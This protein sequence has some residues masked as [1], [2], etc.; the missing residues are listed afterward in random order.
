MRNILDFEAHFEGAKVV[1]LEENYRSRKTILDVANVVLSNASGKRHGKTCVATRDGG[2][3]VQVVVAADPEVEAS[4]VA[5]E[6]QRLIEGGLVGESGRSVRPRDVA[7]LYRSNLQSADIES[8]L[9]ERQIPYRMIGGTQFYERKEVKDLIA[10]LRVAIDPRDELSLR[11]IINYPARGI[12]DAAVTRLASQATAD[13]TGLWNVVGRPDAVSG[14]APAAVEGCRALVRVIEAVRQRFET[15]MKSAEV[16][17]ALVADLGMKEDIHAG[18]TNPQAAARRLGNLESMISV[19]GRRDERGLGDRGKFAEFLRVLALREEGEEEDSGDRVTLT[20]MHGAKGLEF[21]VVFVIGLEEGLLPHGRSLETRATDIALPGGDDGAL[22]GHSL[23]EERRLFY[24]AVTRARDRLYLSRAQIRGMRGKL[25][26]R[27]PSRFLCEIPPE[28]VEE[29]E[30][31]SPVAPGL[32][33][34]KAGAQ[35]VLAILGAL[36][37]GVSGELPFIP[38]PRW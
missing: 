13:S 1:K 27:T 24:V 36:P 12:G 30:E 3:K 16:A 22:G 25:V 15:G 37:G 28:L 26:Q 33:Q 35:N 23:D 14:L 21:P 29:R 2:E 20:T 5:A 18:S 10:Y 31:K 7:V 8:A 9:K 17:R 19:F 38:R 32:E 34:T 6:T 11:R 4:F